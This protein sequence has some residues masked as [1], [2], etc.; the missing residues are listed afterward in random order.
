M[1]HI[2]YNPTW[3]LS[4]FT[5]AKVDK[6]FGYLKDIHS[7]RDWALTAKTKPEQVRL[8]GRWFQLFTILDS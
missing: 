3:W 6:L 8:T 4:N 2:L 1:I 7:G 5:Q